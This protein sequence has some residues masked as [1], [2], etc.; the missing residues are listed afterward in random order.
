MRYCGTRRWSRKTENVQRIQ[1]ANTGGGGPLICRR[2]PAAPCYLSFCFQGR[3]VLSVFIS[4][5]PFISSLLLTTVSDSASTLVF[6]SLKKDE[7]YTVTCFG[8]I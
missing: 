7:K 8:F 2:A 4:F 3:T 5:C 1:E 6:S